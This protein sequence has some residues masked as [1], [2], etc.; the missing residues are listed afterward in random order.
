MA[1]SGYVQGQ[2]NIMLDDGSIPGA[3]VVQENI[4]NL[5]TVR[6]MNSLD[7]S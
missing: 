6:A 4:S 5:K 2:A 3:E 7:L 1:F